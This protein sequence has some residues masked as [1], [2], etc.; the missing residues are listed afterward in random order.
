MSRSKT[1]SSGTHHVV[2]LG[3]FEAGGSKR[4]LNQT[5]GIEVYLPVVLVIAVRPDGEHR[6]GE[7][8]G[9]YLDIGSR[10]GHHIRNARQGFLEGRHGYVHIHSMRQLRSKL[11]SSVSVGGIVLDDI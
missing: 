7:I 8:E 9:Q 3:N 11:N 5:V 10:I 1:R 4:L 6:A 2:L